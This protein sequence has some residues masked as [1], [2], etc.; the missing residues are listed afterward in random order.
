MA[1]VGQGVVVHRAPGRQ[2][3]NALG[4]FRAPTLGAIRLQDVPGG[5][6]RGPLQQGPEVLLKVVADKLGDGIQVETP[7]QSLALAFQ[8]CG[9]PHGQALTQPLGCEERQELIAIGQ[10]QLD[11]AKG[12]NDLHHLAAVHVRGVVARGTV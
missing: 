9:H 11:A 12:I 3:G 10:G 2:L 8:V 7:D 5:P 6:V 1:A 4:I